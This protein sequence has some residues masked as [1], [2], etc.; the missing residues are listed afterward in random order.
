M[1]HAVAMCYLPV[2]G[3]LSHARILSCCAESAKIAYTYAKNFLQTQD[4]DNNFFRV[5]QPVGLAWPAWGGVSL[6]GCPH[7]CSPN[8]GRVCAHALR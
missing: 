4:P 7:G 3:L 6:Q 2:T 1:G 8:A 5:W